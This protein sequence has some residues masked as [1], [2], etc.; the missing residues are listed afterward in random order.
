MRTL[1]AILSVL[2]ALTA[3][4]IALAEEPTEGVIDGQVI[5][6]T[7][8]GGSVAGLY[9]SL[10]AYVEET[11][12][13]TRTTQTDEAG[14]FHFTG[15]PMDCEYLIAVNY[16]EVDYYCA[17]NFSDGENTAEVEIPVCDA[18][19][20]DAAIRVALAHAIIYVEQES[21]SVTEVLW[22]VNDSDRTFVGAE[23]TVVD[24]QQGTLVY[25][26]PEGA[27]DFEPSMEV[28]QGYL[29]LDNNRVA[30]NLAFPPGERETVYSYRLDRPG[31]GDV[32]IPLNIHYPT[33]ILYVMVAGEDIEVAS[34]QLKPAEPVEAETGE[35]FIRF[36]GEFL[37]RGSTIDVRLSSEAQGGGAASAVPWII[38]AIIIIGIVAYLWWRSA[39]PRVPAPAGRTGRADSRRE[40]LLR[41]MA[42][43]DSD[44][45]QGLLDE[46]TYREMYDQKKAQLKEL[47]SPENKENSVE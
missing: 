17:V 25:T 13:E 21:I 45:G 34:S 3:S 4:G 15:L 10:Y 18:T 26:L 1:F 41:E 30:D 8:G 40:Q 22:V 47:E 16:M 36:A 44:L 31:S 32:V 39:H 11:L 6:H 5:N 7:E 37:P 20:S 33:D 43:L 42:R 9:V 46:N 2:L 27:T 28:M 12:G 19:T 35:R 38:G 23:E 14:T 24:G 29:M